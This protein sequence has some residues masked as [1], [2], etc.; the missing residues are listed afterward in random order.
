MIGANANSESLQVEQFT[1]TQPGRDMDRLVA[2]KVMGWEITHRGHRVRPGSDRTSR[3]VGELPVEIGG[4]R[5]VADC[6]QY[7]AG[8]CGRYT[9]SW[10][11]MREVLARMVE[12][13]WGWSV[14][15]Y[16]PGRA[17]AFFHPPDGGEITLK[18]APTVPGA[19]AL[20]AL[21]AL[22]EIHD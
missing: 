17:D 21:T 4:F 15:E 3:S 6:R 16:S 18:S 11:A 1:K 14:D 19:V 8:A 9:T 10:D 5:G 20:A 2:E 7:I 13:G 12:K 22:G